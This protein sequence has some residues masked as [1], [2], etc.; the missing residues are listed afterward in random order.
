MADIAFVTKLTGPTPRAYLPCHMF[1]A[2][3]VCID[4]EFDVADLKLTIRANFVAK[5]LPCGHHLSVST[6]AAW[7]MQL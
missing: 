5:Y 6:A 4:S 2:I 3:S 7:A 1:C